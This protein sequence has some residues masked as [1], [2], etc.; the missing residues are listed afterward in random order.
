MKQAPRMRMFAGPNGSG[1]STMIAKFLKEKNKELL[2]VYINADDIEKLM[3]ENGV[4]KFEEYEVFISKEKIE[5]YFYDSELLKKNNLIDDILLLKIDENLVL[6]EEKT[7]NSYFASVLVS[8]VRYELLIQNK[9]F[10]FE[11]VMSSKDKVDFLEEAQAY[12]YRTYLYYIATDDPIINVNRV[13]NRVTLGGHDVPIDKIESRYV[14]SLSY[15]KKAI[16]NSTRAFIFDNSSEK[17]EMIAEI[18]EKVI[19]FK[20]KKV[21]YW[22]MKAIDQV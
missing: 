18:E 16:M 21:P 5:K 4:F 1:K 20:V 17:P 12:G 13:Q 14:R 10:T 6:F 22:F 2:G 8:I 9:D 3:K 7:I 15:L 19:E 11:T